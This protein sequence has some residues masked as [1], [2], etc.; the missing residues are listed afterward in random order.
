MSPGQRWPREPARPSALPAARQAPGR[1]ANWPGPGGAAE[2]SANLPYASW[3]RSHRHAPLHLRTF[4]SCSSSSIFGA[5]CAFAFSWGS[6]DSVSLSEFASAASVLAAAG[7]ETTGEPFS[8]H[9][10]G[11]ANSRL[12]TPCQGATAAAGEGRERTGAS[13]QRETATRA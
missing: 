8:H 11:A 10:H 12:E 9:R 2:H 6:S 5:P 1:A 13:F 3:D 4:R 7:E